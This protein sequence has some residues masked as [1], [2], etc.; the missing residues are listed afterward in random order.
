[1][2]SGVFIM[3]SDNK[4]VFK[5]RLHDYDHVEEVAHFSFVGSAGTIERFSVHASTFKKL[6]TKGAWDSNK[7]GEQSGQQKKFIDVLKSEVKGDLVQWFE[8]LTNEF[9]KQ[10]VQGTK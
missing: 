2:L 10:M 1:M 9:M 5:I 4:N 6:V 8:E 3:D 7:L